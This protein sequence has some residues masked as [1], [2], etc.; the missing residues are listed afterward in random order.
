M[1]R[2]KPTAGGGTVVVRA[3]ALGQVPAGRLQ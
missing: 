3:G 2:N 1:I